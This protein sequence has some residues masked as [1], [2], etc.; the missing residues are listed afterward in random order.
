MKKVILYSLLFLAIAAIINACQSADEIEMAKYLSNGKDIYESRC[1]NCHGKNGEGLGE[2][3]P[4]L[5]DTVFLKANKQQLACYIKNG[6]NQPML[7]NGKTYQEK[8]P[9]FKDL[10]DIDVAQVIVYITNSFGNKQGMY[11]Y[12]KVAIDLNNCQ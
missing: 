3:A 10:H 9:A 1:Q 6:A 12:E 11:K 8:M 4:P 2:L 5:T 7:I